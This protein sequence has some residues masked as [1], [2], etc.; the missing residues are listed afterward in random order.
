ME[1]VLDQHMDTKK[2]WKIPVPKI[3]RPQISQAILFAIGGWTWAQHAKY[4]ETYDIRADRW[5]EVS[6]TQIYLYRA[7]LNNACKKH[8]FFLFCLF[9]SFNW[10]PLYVYLRLVT[11]MSTLFA[12]FFR[13]NSFPL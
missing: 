5:K 13:N 10:F 11:S 8:H 1:T 7:L 6:C 3:F 4:I 12:S 9:L 2:G